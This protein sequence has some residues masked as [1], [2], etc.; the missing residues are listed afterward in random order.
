MTKAANRSTKRVN[1]Q[2]TVDP[3]DKELIAAMLRYGAAIGTALTTYKLEPGGNC[4]RS[5]RIADRAFRRAHSEIALAA[6][7]PAQTMEGLS[8]KARAVP[9]IFQDDEGGSLSTLH[10]DYLTSLA[11]DTVRLAEAALDAECAAKGGAK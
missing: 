8:A 2:S 11:A 4:D 5:G 3:D 1:T 6:A 9:F 7:L 10:E